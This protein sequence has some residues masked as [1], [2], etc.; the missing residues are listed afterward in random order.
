MWFQFFRQTNSVESAYPMD[1]ISKPLHIT[2]TNDALN[3]RYQTECNSFQHRTQLLYANV[4][5]STF[6]ITKT[7]TKIMHNTLLLLSLL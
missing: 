3:I 7:G 5:H 2:I 6:V 4:F 1:E